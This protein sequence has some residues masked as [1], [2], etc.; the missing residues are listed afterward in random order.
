MDG[1]FVGGLG[2]LLP[3]GAGM[4]REAGGLPACPA[5]PVH[6]PHTN[7]PHTLYN[8]TTRLGPEEGD[9]EGVVQQRGERPAVHH[10]GVARQEAAQPVVVVSCVWGVEGVGVWWLLFRVI[11]G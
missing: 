8:T 3:F 7:P 2:S 1:C 4:D 6:D 11:L 5:C 10:P 9:A